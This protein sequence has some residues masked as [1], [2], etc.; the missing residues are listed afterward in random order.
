M[1]VVAVVGQQALLLVQQ[2]LLVARLQFFNAQ[3]EHIVFLTDYVPV[4][5]RLGNVV[6]Q[7]FV[8][9]LLRGQVRI[10]TVQLVTLLVF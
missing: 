3:A 2:L 10:H 1:H 9:T 4:T 5:L 8:E 6:F 7:F